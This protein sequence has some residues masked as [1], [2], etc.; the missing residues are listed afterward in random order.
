[1][2]EGASHSEF[3]RSRDTGD[4]FFLETSARVGGAHIPD[5]I[6]AGTGVNLWTEWAK[7]ETSLVLGS[8]YSVP[9]LRE[10]YAGLLVSLA[11]QEW[12]DTSVF[13][14]PEVVWK[15]TKKHHVGLVVRS[16]DGS[17]VAELIDS[18]TQLVREDFHASAPPR[19]KVGF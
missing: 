16:S 14:A 5:L 10:E 4:I 8:P 18:Y 9:E 3:I 1:M 12:P 19:E 2:R 11:R 13:S 15:L 7:L 6:E 17:R